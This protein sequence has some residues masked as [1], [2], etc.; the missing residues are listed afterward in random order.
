MERNLD[1]DSANAHRMWT[2]SFIPIGRS[3]LHRTIAK[4][5]GGKEQKS[6]GAV[7]VMSACGFILKPWFLDGV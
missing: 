7:W 2:F 6:G 3:Y 4:S 1:P 5:V